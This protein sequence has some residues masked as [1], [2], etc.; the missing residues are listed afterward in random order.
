[1]AANT[2]LG[3]TN[4]QT[5]GTTTN[6]SPTV[7]VRPNARVDRIDQSNNSGEVQA[8]KVGSVTVNKETNPWLLLALVLGWVAPSPSQLGEWVKNLFTRKKKN[9][10]Q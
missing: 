3:K 7:T 4:S 1:M 6:V 10:S 9:G 5:L 8:D 2:Q